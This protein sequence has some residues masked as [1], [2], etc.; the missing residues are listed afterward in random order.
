MVSHFALMV[1]FSALVSAVFA[2][3]Q[4]DAPREQLRYGAYLFAGFV[5]VGFLLGWAMLIFPLGS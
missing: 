1:L 2:V 4:R 5:G 3:L